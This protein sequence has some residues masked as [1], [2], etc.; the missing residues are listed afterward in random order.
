MCIPQLLTRLDDRIQ[1][2]AEANVSRPVLGHVADP[3]DARI[4]VKC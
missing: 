4:I 2:P 3:H 1:F